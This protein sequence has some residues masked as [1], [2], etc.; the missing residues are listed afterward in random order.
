[1]Q[2]SYGQVYTNGVIGKDVYK[3]TADVTTIA[4]PNLLVVN[5]SMPDALAHD[6]TKLLYDHA[7]DLVKV[8]PEGRNIV[9]DNGPRTEPVV[10]HTGSKKYFDG[11]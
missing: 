3:L 1:L 8:H 9:R 2:S 10:L 4:V 11:Q 6:L 5:A 7:A